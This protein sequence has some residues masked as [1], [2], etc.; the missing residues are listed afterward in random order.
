MKKKNTQPKN[1]KPTTKSILEIV[2]VIM[3][4]GLIL[5]KILL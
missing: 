2:K 5:A 3:D 4:I 1:E